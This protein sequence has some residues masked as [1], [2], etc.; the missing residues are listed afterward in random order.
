M[1]NIEDTTTMQLVANCM[2]WA[3]HRRRKAATK[4]HLNL[5]LNIF[6]P[7]F[8]ILK[9]GRTHDSKVTKSLCAPIKDGE[10]VIF[11]KADG[12]AA[13]KIGPQHVQV[14]RVAKAR[15]TA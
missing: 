14:A 11:D 1:I 15:R 9:Q 13:S 6:P 8:A 5:N 12:R 4:L 2:G 3:K 7:S 10:I